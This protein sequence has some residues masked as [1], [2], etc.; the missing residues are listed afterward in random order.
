MTPP[1]LLSNH[2]KHGKF[3][4]QITLPL[5][6]SPRGESHDSQASGRVISHKC[7]NM[8]KEVVG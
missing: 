1:P 5:A 4:K 2:A 7:R 8:K 3:A 6:Y